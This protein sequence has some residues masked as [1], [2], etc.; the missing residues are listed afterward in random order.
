MEDNTTL[1]YTF[2]GFAEVD[3]D[4]LLAIQQNKEL[5]EAVEREDDILE[6]P[7]C[8][9]DATLVYFSAD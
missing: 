6:F 8:T 7:I 4:L 1:S 3:P 5:M 9:T 2:Y